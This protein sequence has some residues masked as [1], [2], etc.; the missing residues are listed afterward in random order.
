MTRKL[1]VKRLDMAQ[2]RQRLSGIQNSRPAYQSLLFWLVLLGICL[3][4]GW[5]AKG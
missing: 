5:L 2:H 4:L 1:K 3:G